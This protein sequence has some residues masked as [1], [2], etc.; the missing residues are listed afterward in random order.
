[1]GSIDLKTVRRHLKR[2][3]KAAA[4]TAVLLA[5][6]HAAAPHLSEDNLELCP[7]PLFKR[8]DRLYRIEQEMHLRAG[9][10]RVDLPGLRYRLQA[11]LWQRYGKVSTSFPSRSP[12]DPWYPY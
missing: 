1:M 4:E 12:P 7:L 10:G 6:R 8:L 5:A 9:T 3:E 2:L 11:V